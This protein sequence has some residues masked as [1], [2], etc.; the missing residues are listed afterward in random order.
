MVIVKKKIK[1]WNDTFY[2]TEGWIRNILEN[3]CYIF[4]F[5]WAE[6]KFEWRLTFKLDNG[7]KNIFLQVFNKK[8]VIAALYEP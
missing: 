2:Y 6:K 4:L 5:F 1:L 8:A 7:L 3:R